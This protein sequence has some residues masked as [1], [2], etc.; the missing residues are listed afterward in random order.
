MILDTEDSDVHDPLLDGHVI[1]RLRQE[2]GQRQRIARDEIE[3]TAMTRTNDAI[4]LYPALSEILVLMRADATDGMN[5]PAESNQQD[6]YAPHECPEQ[7]AFTD[8]AIAC[9]RHKLRI[10]GHKLGI[11][12]I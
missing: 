3:F 1:H 5:D 10:H 11:S 7:F 9:Y 4:T 2:S 8:F 6:G 12:P